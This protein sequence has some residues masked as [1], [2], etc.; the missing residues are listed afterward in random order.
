MDAY[1]KRDAVAIGQLFTPDAEFYDEFG[2]L[3]VGRESIVAMFQDVFETSP[4]ALV[5]EIQIERIRPLSQMVV[6]EEGFVSTSESASGPR[7]RSRYVALH[8]KGNDGTWR[9]NTL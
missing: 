1:A 8:T 3:T 6:L 9:I 4:E 5:D 7:H 2:E